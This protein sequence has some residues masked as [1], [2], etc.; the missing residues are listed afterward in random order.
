MILLCSV[1]LL[2]AMTETVVQVPSYAPYVSLGV[3]GAPTSGF[4]PLPSYVEN[5]SPAYTAD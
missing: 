5:F 4:G 2:H 1:A 3:T